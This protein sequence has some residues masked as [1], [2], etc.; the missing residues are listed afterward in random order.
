MWSVEGGGHLQCFQKTLTFLRKILRFIIKILCAV[1]ES[2]LNESETL[3]K[4]PPHPPLHPDHACSSG[5]N[6]Q[7][8]HRRR[9]AHHATK[10]VMTKRT[11]HLKQH[12]ESERLEIL[13]YTIFG[14][15]VG[16][17]FFQLWT[18]SNLNIKKQILYHG[19]PSAYKIHYIV[20]GKKVHRTQTDQ[21]HATEQIM[22]SSVLLP[23]SLCFA[24]TMHYKYLIC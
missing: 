16:P 9:V 7:L 15:V 19:C 4:L 14:D 2:E 23:L 21:Q 17:V 24:I 1:G 12:Q 8:L 5:S 11:I 20:E 18:G 3:L 6:P 13:D 10:D 22:Q